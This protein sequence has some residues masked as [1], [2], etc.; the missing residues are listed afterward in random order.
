MKEQRPI[1]LAAGGTG[2]HLFPAEALA[3]ALARRG[4]EIELA[5]DDRALNYGAHFPAKAIHT[6]ASAT[7]RGGSFARKAHAALTLA[8]GTGTAY[9][10]LQKIKPACVIGFGGYPTVPPVLAASLLNIPTLVHE[11]NAVLGRANQFLAGRVTA[12]ATGFAQIGGLADKNRTKVVHTGNPIRPA[13]LHAAKLPYPDF[14]D[15]KWR[16]VV[17]GGSQGARVMS[18]I[19]PEALALL[20]IEIRSRLLLVQ[21]ARGEDQA[22][23]RLAYQNLNIEAEIAPFF[24]DLPMR[25]AQAHLVIARAGASTVSELAVIGRPS[26]LVPFPFALDQD[27]AANAA[28]LAQTGAAHVIA[29]SQFTP[30]WLSQ[31]LLESFHSPQTLIHQAQAAKS[32]GLP[33]AAERL[34]DLVLRLASS[35]PLAEPPHETA[36]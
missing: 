36:A 17:T 23:V 1:L 25:M 3:N 9:V 27:Q 13:V 29:Q 28:H 35:S 24:R 21:Q 11:Q 19:V 16:I 33:D 12:I 31:T 14:D 2:G 7:P 26:I 5:T 22:R 30:Q 4:Y 20:P 6:I 8:L 18:D 15:G 34:A 32:A 10:K